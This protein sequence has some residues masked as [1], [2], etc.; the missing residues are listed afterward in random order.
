MSNAAKL[1]KKKRNKGKG[2][3]V[4]INASRVYPW[5]GEVRANRNS[6]S[7]GGAGESKK[8]KK[9]KKRSEKFKVAKGYTLL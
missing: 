4:R 5:G 2:H 1:G 9:K 8:K 7:L 6:Q 3:G